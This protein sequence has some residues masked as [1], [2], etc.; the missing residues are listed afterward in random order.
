MNR[1]DCT[2]DNSAKKTISDGTIAQRK[3]NCTEARLQR[4]QDCNEVVEPA[5]RKHKHQSLPSAGPLHQKKTQQFEGNQ[6]IKKDREINLKK[7]QS[8]RKARSSKALS[9]TLLLCT[10]INVA[11]A[12]SNFLLTTN[13]FIHL[14]KQIRLV[15]HSNRK[16]K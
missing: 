8:R 5:T 14:S 13:T 4:G 7:M 6:E 16:K 1:Q 15:S 11:N 12:Q 3:Q 2:W 10:F 9:F